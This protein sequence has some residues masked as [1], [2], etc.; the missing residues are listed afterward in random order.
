MFPSRRTRH[1]VAFRPS[2]SPRTALSRAPM[3]NV[4]LYGCNGHQ[5]QNALASHPH[6]R[7][8][9]VAQIPLE[10]LPDSIRNDPSLA[11]HTTLE[12]ILR[13]PKV[14]S[15]SLC[16]PRRCD[17]ASDAVLA[18][19]AGKHV[20]AEKPCALSEAE[21]DDIISAANASG[22]IFREMAGTAFGGP[23]L[24]MRNAVRAGRIG[25]VVQVISEKSY[26]YYEGR[27]QDERVDGG[28][29]CQNAI[30]AVRFIEHVACTPIRSVAAVETTNGNPLRNGGLRMASCMMFRLANGGVA[31]VTANYLNPRGTGVWGYETLRILGTQGMVESVAGTGRTRLVIG[32]TD[33][34]ELPEATCE[35]YLTSF[36]K[37]ALGIGTMPLSLEEELS[38]TRWVLRAKAAAEAAEAREAHAAS[39]AA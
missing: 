12:H 38:P 3:L 16:S 32:A 26:P 36:I 1:L 7:V 11:T 2:L 31:S 8:V 9:A 25:D 4:A 24:A 20:Y 6:A 30:H 10:K 27:P 29:I 35:D 34:G 17:Q 13:D 22:K 19:R 23:Y 37:T 39:A 15:V 5:I 14:D 33:M 28:L 21:L 18:L